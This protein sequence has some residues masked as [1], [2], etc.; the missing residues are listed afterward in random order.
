MN[1]LVSIIIPV[2]N[3]ENYLDDCLESVIK[4]THKSWEVILIDDGSTDGTVKLCE[5]YV[6]KDSRFQM[7][8]S[9]H[10]GVSVARNKG[11]GEAKG[12][13]VFF[14][15]SDDAIHPKL[16]ETF[17]TAMHEKSASIGGTKIVHVLDEKWHKVQ[18][19]IKEGSGE[20]DVTYQN[21]EETL[22]AMFCTESPLSEIGGVIM[23]RDLIGETEFDDR[24]YIGEDFYFIYQNLIK[25]ADSIFIDK[26]WYY[27][28]SHEGN[29]TWD[30]GFSGFYNRF[31]RR[32]AVWI[33]EE[34][35][36]R[37]EY[38]NIQKRQAFGMFVM[39]AKRNKPYGAECKRMREFIKK[40]KKILFPAMTFKE[41]IKYYLCVY[42][43]FVV[44]FL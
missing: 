11:L 23:R 5:K 9:D 29:S 39:C 24:F 6:K 33:S 3:R 20:V 16:L 36:G 34:N 30:F 35:F 18:E 43:P 14:L 19:K 10:N 27:C 32:E 44:E 41:K 8:L 13:F 26:K 15:D 12:E 2:Y 22:H 25:G 37:K 4:Q 40:Q 17:V 42:V 1:G 21:H 31:Q 7:I 38:T 28:R